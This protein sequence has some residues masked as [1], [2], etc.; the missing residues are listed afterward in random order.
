MI[1]SA[2]TACSDEEVDPSVTE[3]ERIEGTWIIESQSLLGADVPGDGSSLT[4]NFC[5]VDTACDG[6]DYLASDETSGTF[7]FSFN[8]DKSKIIFE[9]NDAEAGGY[10]DGEWTIDEFTSTSLTI[11]VDTGIFGVTT[12]ELRKQ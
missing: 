11:S 12:L 2:F 8:A 9:D 1:V 6:I 3:Y 4:F 5:G 10:Y 7:S